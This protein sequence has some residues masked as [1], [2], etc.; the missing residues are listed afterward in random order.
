MQI[1]IKRLL[2]IVFSLIGLLLALPIL[3]VSAFFIKSTPGPIFFLQLRLGLHGKIFKILK[4]RTLTDNSWT[5]GS[6][7]LVSEGDS[8]VTTIG[9]YLRRTHFDELPQLVNVLRGEMSIVGPRPA[10][11][12]HYDYYEDWEMLRLDMRP[13]ITGLS[14]VSG[15]N[16][17]SWNER[18]KLDVYYVK[19]WS[20]FLDFKIIFLT[21]WHFILRCI[22]GGGIHT[23]KD[24]AWDR[25]IPEN[26]FTNSIDSST[27]KE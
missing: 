18:I 22:G 12:F 9:K 16:T 26:P 27:P 19:N 8:R 24:S 14:Q 6:G 25:D 13:G 1:L 4:L 17:L 21:I 5:L 2:D 3:I 20:L 10:L 7:L 23:T 11:P 15:A